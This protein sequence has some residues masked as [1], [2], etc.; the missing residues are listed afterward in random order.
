M[1]DEIL[2]HLYFKAAEYV[3]D[4]TFGTHAREIRRLEDGWKFFDEDDPKAVAADYDD[5]DWRN[6]SVPHDYSIEG[7]FSDKHAAN[8]FVQTGILWYR[9]EIRLN[10]GDSHRKIRLVF[11]GVSMNSDVWINGRHLGFHPYPFTPFSYDISPFVQADESQPNLLAVRADCSIQPYGRSYVGAGIF[12]QVCLVITNPLHVESDGVTATTRF[13]ANGDASVRI[14]TRIQVGRYPETVWN[15]FS[16]Q[17]TGCRENNE[18]VK[19]CELWTSIIDDEGNEADV[20]RTILRIPHFSRHEQVQ[21]L[22]VLHPKR[23]EIETPHVYRIITRLVLEGQ[24][25]DDVITPLGIR[26]IEI[27][28]R[29]GLIFNGRG[30]KLQGVCLHQDSAIF[31]GAVPLP[32]WFKKLHLLKKAGCNAI[33]TAH[34]PFPEE[35]YHLCDHMGLLVLDEAFDEWESGWER[36]YLEGPYGKN[37]YGY[38]QSFRQWHETD[39][40][41]ML[42]RD[43]VHPCVILWSIGNEIPEL[44]FPE[45]KAVLKNLTAICK[46]EDDS[47]PVTVCAEG[48]HI[49]PIR[50]ELMDMVDVA[51]YNYVNSREGRA[52]YGRIHISHPDRVLL[53]T[54]TEYEPEHWQYILDHPYVIGQF[55]WVGY[56]YLGEGTDLFGKDISLGQTFDIGVLA[57]FDQENKRIL[58]HGWEYGLVDL[59]DQPRGEYFYRKKIWQKEPFVK[60]AVQKDPALPKASYACYGADMHWNW[61][62]GDLKT[63]IC[64]TNCIEM[65]IF[66]NGRSLGRKQRPTG[67]CDL[68]YWIVPYEPG[69]LLAVGT[70]DR[71]TACVDML[72]TAGPPERIQI[73]SVRN[74]ILPGGKDYADFMISICDSRGIRVPFADFEIIAEVD[75]AGSLLGVFNSDMTVSRGFRAKSCHTYLGA[76]RAVVKSGLFPGAIHIRVRCDQLIS[77]D[78]ILTCR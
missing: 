32:E 51:G 63:I 14:R 65:E 27:D 8:G 23:W 56:D 36:D 9:M 78:A 59:V 60:L 3:R 25:I 29:R 2:D 53:G 62:T 76:A 17:G 55:L 30:M 39:L 42:R 34:H 52:M 57:S 47:R 71:G 72:E 6:V 37:K 26:D 77:G 19:I 69:E 1:K 54:E 4:M 28:A 35:F 5:S 66:L 24:V 75:G 68:L 44:Y 43:R 49:L 70:S 64:L 50:D 67:F 31:G 40:R 74:R 21:E 61:K 11:D 58:R 73:T 16:W 20:K 33:R 15:A 41:A 48:N 12:R 13:A 38:S 7:E 10:P 46:K 45:G 22:T 18:I